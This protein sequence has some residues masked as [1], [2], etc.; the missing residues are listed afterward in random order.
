VRSERFT[1]IT[2]EILFTFSAELK[3]LWND[4]KSCRKLSPLMLFPIRHVTTGSKIHSF[5]N[6]AENLDRMSFVINTEGHC[7]FVP[8]IC[9]TYYY[10]K[11]EKIIFLN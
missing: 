8:E 6:S 5:F 1:F 3:K 7:T 9:P 4:H 11:S 2:N 10:D